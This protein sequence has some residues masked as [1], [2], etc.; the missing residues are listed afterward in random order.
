M[1][2]FFGLTC[3]YEDMSPVLIPAGY[4][5][6][7]IDGKITAGDQL[8]E[9]HAAF[10]VSSSNNDNNNNNNKQR[11]KSWTTRVFENSYKC[12]KKTNI[13]ISGGIR[14][15]QMEYTRRTSEDANAGSSAPEAPRGTASACFLCIVLFAL[16]FHCSFLDGQW[17]RKGSSGSF[18]LVFLSCVDC[19]GS[20]ILTSAA[21]RLSSAVFL[22]AQ[23]SRALRDAQYVYMV[24]RGRTQPLQR[25][26]GETECVLF[27]T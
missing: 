8:K 18:I 11:A 17:S 12:Q 7:Y 16:L 5:R 24:I 9:V 26:A 3:R 22:L 25:W 14:G 6:D 13:Y 2:E 15:R 27:N 10:Q 20:A 1:K 4:T 21:R 19:A 23:R